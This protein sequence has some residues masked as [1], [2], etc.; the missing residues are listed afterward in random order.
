MWGSQ[1][2]STVLT[3]K[4]VW[5]SLQFANSAEKEVPLYIQSEMPPSG[6]KRKKTLNLR[7]Q[8]QK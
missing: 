4:Q 5:E 8:K 2:K 1:K 6:H 7:T 3:G